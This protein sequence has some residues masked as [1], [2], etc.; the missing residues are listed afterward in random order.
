MDM[1]FKNFSP[2]KKILLILSALVII[3]AVVIVICYF[4]GKGEDVEEPPVI[5][6]LP[7][8]DTP[9]L[10]ELEELAD[11]LA[12]PVGASDA[13]VVRA[14]IPE[15]VEEDPS[16]EPSEEP[17][18][19]EK[20]S[21]PLT[22]AVTYHYEG[23]PAVQSR[24]ELYCSLLTA[25]DFGFV[26]VD[27]EMMETVLPTFEEITEGAIHL[28]LPIRTDKSGAEVKEATLFSLQISWNAEKCVITVGRIAGK[29]VVPRPENNYRP[30]L[31]IATAV[32]YFYSC[33][34]S[35][36][37]LPGESMDVYQVLPLDGAVLVGTMPCLRI[38]VYAI[39]ERTGT[40]VIAGQ[41]LLADNGM[42]LYRIDEKGNIVALPR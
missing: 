23:I 42:Q 36:F 7:I 18:E 31:T 37:G 1:K 28:V 25:E 26:P 12:L 3:A 32:D 22:V 10:Y 34:P 21:H 4:S 8:V 24:V 35:Q 27:G 38:N 14:D 20:E 9:M 5:K 19:A 39:D 2:K 15:E 41:Y 11:V 30:P 29:I 13:I 33:H 6:E 40:N 17:A 16:V